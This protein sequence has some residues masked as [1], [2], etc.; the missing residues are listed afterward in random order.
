MPI[1]DSV[2]PQIGQ[3]NEVVSAT[4]ATRRSGGT[5]P[6]SVR[7]GGRDIRLVLSPAARAQLTRLTAP[8]EIELEVYFSCYLRKRVRFLRTAHADVFDRV[9]LN[10]RVSLSVRTVMTR[11]CAVADAP[12]EPELDPLPLV[13]P[14]AFVPR[15]V[16]LDYAGDAWSGEFGFQPAS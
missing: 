15:W 3:E 9:P 14:G 6:A 7:L 16:S 12:D 13:R 1:D 10:D 4:A 5:I 2:K 8:L 11:A